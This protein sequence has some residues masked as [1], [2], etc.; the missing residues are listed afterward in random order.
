VAWTFLTN[1]AHVLVVIATEPG[2]RLRD[3]ADAVGIT[4]S[5]AHRLVVDLEREGYLTRHRLGLRN[6]YEVHPHRPLRHDLEKEVEIGDVLSVLLGRGP[7]G[8]GSGDG[9]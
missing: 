5:A 2:M 1:H 9:P 8:S 7:R 3:I 6:F 4:E